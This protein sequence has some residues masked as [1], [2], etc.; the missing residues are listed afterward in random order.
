MAQTYAAMVIA[1]D[2]KLVITEHAYDRMKERNGWSR[3]TSNRML[4]RIYADG[5][6]PG[7]IKGYLKKWVNNKS[8]Y[9]TDGGECIL[10][11]EKLYIFKNMK[12]VT[13]IPVPSRGYLLRE[14]LF[15]EG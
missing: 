12:M 6:R 3:K 8:Y 9:E 13:V 5:L 10:F 11:G 1:D 7:Q 15:V 14:K 2:E 4:R